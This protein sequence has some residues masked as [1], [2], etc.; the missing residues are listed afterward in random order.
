MCAVHSVSADV[1]SASCVNSLGPVDVTVPLVPIRPV[2]HKVLSASP[3][4]L[5]QRVGHTLPDPMI[6]TT[7]VRVCLG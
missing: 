5:T 7:T 3:T 2:S 6:Q 1:H 4:G